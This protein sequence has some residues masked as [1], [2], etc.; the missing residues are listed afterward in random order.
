MPEL[1]WS[2]EMEEVMELLFRIQVDHNGSLPES[3]AQEL[4][5]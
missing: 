4:G 2:E 3:E 1:R 5:P